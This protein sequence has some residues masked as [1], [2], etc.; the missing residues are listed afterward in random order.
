[1]KAW[2][3]AV[4]ADRAPQPIGV[5]RVVTDYATVAYVCDVFVDQDW[6]GRGALRHMV[7]HLLHHPQLA[8][9]RRFVPRSRD[10]RAAA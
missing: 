5:A 10:V 1:M 9:L 2:I 8:G 3:G 4:V 7:E 6:R